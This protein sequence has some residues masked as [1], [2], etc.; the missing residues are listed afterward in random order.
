M[1]ASPRTETKNQKKKGKEE[2]LIRRTLEYGNAVSI[3]KIEQNYHTVSRIAKR[4][5]TSV[6][7]GAY[8][9]RVF[10]METVVVASHPEAHESV[11]S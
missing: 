3:K 7:R 8:V 2:A 9:P 1:D 5:P 10:S 6:E 4:R 11:L